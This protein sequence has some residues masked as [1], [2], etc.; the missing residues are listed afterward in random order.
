MTLRPK[1]LLWAGKRLLRYRHFMILI[2]LTLRL[3][4]TLLFTIIVKILKNNTNL[5]NAELAYRKGC[6]LH[7]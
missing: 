4:E 3:Y 7:K 6:Y 1:T 5:R 2:I